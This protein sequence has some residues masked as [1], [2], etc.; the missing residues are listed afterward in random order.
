MYQLYVNISLFWKSLLQ[1]DLDVE[2]WKVTNLKYKYVDSLTSLLNILNHSLQWSP[3]SY[4]RYT[5]RVEAME[6]LTDE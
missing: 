6:D 1:R 4:K 2:S 3:H 5:P